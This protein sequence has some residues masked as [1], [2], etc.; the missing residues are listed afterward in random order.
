MYPLG[1][2]AATATT[3]TNHYGVSSLSVS[4]AMK[5]STA[6]STPSD[7]PSS[8]R[9]PRLDGVGSCVEAGCSWISWHVVYELMAQSWGLC[10]WVSLGEQALH[11]LRQHGRLEAKSSPPNPSDTTRRMVR[12]GTLFAP[13]LVVISVFAA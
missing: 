8:S 10:G 7:A 4:T 11:S 9:A 3:R 13:S 12:I 6:A 1:T 2:S 5:L